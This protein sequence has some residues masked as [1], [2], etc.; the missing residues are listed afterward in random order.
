VSSPEIIAYASRTGTKRNLDALRARQWRL[1][2]SATGV[3]RD[4][5]FDE[6]AIDNGAW[7]AFL[8]GRE[9]DLDLLWRCLRL[10]GARANW[11]T[12]PDIVAGGQRS[13]E[14]SLTWMRRVLDECQMALLPVQDGMTVADVEGVIGARVGIFVGG[15]TAWKLQTMAQWSELARAR[16]AWCHVA[17]VNTARRIAA[18][19]AVGATSF[20]GTSATRYAKTLPLLDGAKRQRQLRFTEGS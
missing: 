20:D 2:I 19:Q 14:L 1:L 7:A 17:R 18:C 3:L 6:V 9:I 12:L 5:G 15:S 8:K 10:F 4:E 11:A 16:G 13:L